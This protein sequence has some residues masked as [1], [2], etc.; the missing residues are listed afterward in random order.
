D[1]LVVEA[2]RAGVFRSR[3][4]RSG[5]EG[6]EQPARSGP[7]RAE[8]HPF[9][10]LVTLTEKFQSGICWLW[11]KE[12][13]AHSEGGSGQQKFAINLVLGANLRLAREVG[14]E[15]DAAVEGPERRLR[16]QRESFAVSS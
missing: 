6:Q 12:R 15:K 16:T 10:I 1:L 9:V 11:I 3:R 8:F 5:T 13:R 2:S 4:N 7:L 14:I